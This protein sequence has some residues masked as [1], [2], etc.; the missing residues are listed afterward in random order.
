MLDALI[1]TK[2]GRKYIVKNFDTYDS[3]KDFVQFYSNNNGI[4]EEDMCINKN[5]IES[6]VFDDHKKWEGVFENGKY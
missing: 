3:S 2:S 1:T 4:V 6:I 5:C